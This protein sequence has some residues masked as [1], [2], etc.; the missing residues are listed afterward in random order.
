[1]Y[2]MN[3]H[4]SPMERSPTCLIGHIDYWEGEFRDGILG[5]E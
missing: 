4:M 1:M 3:S 5:P 2:F